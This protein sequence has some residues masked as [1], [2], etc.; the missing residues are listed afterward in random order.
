WLAGFL[1][2]RP[3]VMHYPNIILPGSG[4]ARAS[5]VRQMLA[6]SIVD[7][8][9]IPW[10]RAA[11]PGAMLLKGVLTAED[12]RRSMDAGA[13]GVIVSNHGG[14]QLDTCYPTVRAL[15]AIVRA[16]GAQGIVIVDGGIR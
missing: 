8:S 10:I 2:D 12:A 15:P 1:G 6:Q 16:I 5:D 13:A 9:D 14:R 7:W 4:P 3:A 11:W